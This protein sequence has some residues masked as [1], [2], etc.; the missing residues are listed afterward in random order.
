[1][2]VKCFYGENMPDALRKIKA[3]MGIDAVIVQTRKCRRGGLFGFFRP[4]LIEVIAAAGNE[5]RA[6]VLDRDRGERLNEL[7]ITSNN[8]VSQ[9]ITDLKSIIEEQISRDKPYQ[10]YPGQFEHFYQTLLS[11]DVS[12]N[13]ARD[14]IDQALHMVDQTNW[15]NPVMVKEE[16]QK[17]IAEHLGVNQKKGRRKKEKIALVGPT[18]VGK[19][20]TIAKLAAIS[21]V[22]EEK[23]VALITIDTY[24]I[25]AVDQLKT[26]ADIISL[27]MDVAHTPKELKEML[28]KH[29][30]KDLTLVDTAGRSPLNKLQVAEVKGFLDACPDIKVYLVLS[31]TTNQPDLSEITQRFS[32]FPVVKLIFT[33]LDETQSY[34]RI[35]NTVVNVQKG[36]AYVT[37]GQNVPD[38][39]EV[40]SLMEIAEL[41]MRER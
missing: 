41:I 10:V 25:G 11:N 5:N 16:V 9:Q 23:E 1:M 18:G 15:Q 22:M 26:Y 8:S 39:I 7:L 6:P 19:T 30:N 20:T 28:I 38:D 17:I 27:P 3:D 35:L 24:R 21:S 37:A 40:P 14:I 32:H 2:K 36:L 13:L 33:K 31:A 4:P 12:E 29:K 34:G